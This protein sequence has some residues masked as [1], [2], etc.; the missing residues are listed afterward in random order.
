MVRVGSQS[1]GVT[2]YLSSAGAGELGEGL[3][4]DRDAVATDVGRG[5]A[6]PDGSTVAGVTG[7]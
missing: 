5:G 1:A 3:S 4:F 6:P 7:D 2:L